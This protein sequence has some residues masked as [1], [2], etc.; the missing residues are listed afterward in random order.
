MTFRPA[1]EAPD[2]RRIRRIC[3]LLRRPKRRFLANLQEFGNRSPQARGG[4][5]GCPRRSG[6]GGFMRD[7]RQ[8]L[9]GWMAAVMRERGWTAAAWAKQAAVTPTNLTRFLRDP[10]GASLPGAETIGRLALAAGSE[11]RFLDGEPLPGA[12]RVPLLTVA[13]LRVVAGLGPEDA[14]AFLRK[15]LRQ[16]GEAVLID[17][18]PSDRAFAITVTSA[19]LNAGGVIHDDQ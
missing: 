18:P 6:G 7:T 17:R 19:H 11:P 4:I 3:G 8:A 1:L 12:G 9:Y 2:S 14:A 16:G 5:G 15:T 13:Q 10:D